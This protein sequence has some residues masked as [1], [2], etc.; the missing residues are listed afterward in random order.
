MTRIVA[1]LVGL[2]FL[3]FTLF[4]AIL[5]AIGLMPRPAVT[6]TPSPHSTRGGSATRDGGAETQP[7]RIGGVSPLLVGAVLFLLLVAWMMTRRP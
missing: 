6:A 1:A 4:V 3:P 7:R 5:V 2:V